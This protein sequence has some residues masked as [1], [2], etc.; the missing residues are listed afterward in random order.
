MASFKVKTVYE[1]G[2]P[3]KG[4]RVVFAF[5]GLS[6]GN[7]KEKYTDSNGFAYFSNYD[8]GEA[9]IIVDGTTRIRRASV[10]DGD[11]FTVTVK[12]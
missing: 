2:E 3:A 11:T 10:N 1:S 12:A 7:T 9:D 4:C 5:Y 6:R 8:E